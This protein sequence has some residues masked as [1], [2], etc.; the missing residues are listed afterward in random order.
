LKGVKVDL[1][2]PRE[3]WDDPSAEVTEMK[4]QCESL[5]ER[6]EA[7]IEE[8][9]ESHQEEISLID[10][11]CRDRVLKKKDSG[12]LYETLKSKHEAEKSRQEL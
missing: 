11:L 9:Y 4:R 7:D 8:W 3:L 5:V 6:H 1:G 2:I 12:C 10:F